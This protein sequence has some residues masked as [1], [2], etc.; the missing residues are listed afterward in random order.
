MSSGI[1][2]EED[3]FS[4]NYAKPANTGASNQNYSYNNYEQP[5]ER[6]ITGWLMKHGLAKSPQGAQVIM[7]VIVVINMIITGV[8][9]TFLL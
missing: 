4:R 6:G 1:E 5:A 2:F 9:L 7:L 3:S 8:F